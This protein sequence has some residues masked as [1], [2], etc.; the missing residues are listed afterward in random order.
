[1]VYLSLIHIFTP[2]Y[3]AESYEVK[4]GVGYLV[5]RLAQ[6]IGRELEHRMGGIGLTDAPVSYTHLDVY[7]RQ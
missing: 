2:F 4:S 7:K 3:Q 6:A 1:M 5:N